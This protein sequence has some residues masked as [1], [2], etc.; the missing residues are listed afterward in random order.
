MHMGDDSAPIRTDEF[1]DSF[2]HI[3]NFH[4]VNS[5]TKDIDSIISQLGPLVFQAYSFEKLNFVHQTTLIIT[6][7]IS[8]VLRNRTL[9]ISTSIFM[10]SWETNGTGVFVSIV[11]HLSMKEINFDI[12]NIQP[13]TD[14]P[15]RLQELWIVG[16]FLNCPAKP[17]DVYI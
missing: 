12:L 3:I 11:F 1:L 16:V 7:A 8:I 4:W 10:E 14:P 9:A 13:V 6:S 5:D 15:D 17:A 2:K